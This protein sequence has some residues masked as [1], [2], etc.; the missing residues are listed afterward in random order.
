MTAGRSAGDLAAGWLYTDWIQEPDE[1]QHT[2]LWRGCSA[3]SWSKGVAV[4]KGCLFRSSLEPTSGITTVNESCTVS[5][6]VSV[7]LQARAGRASGRP[8]NGQARQMGTGGRGV[9]KIGQ[10]RPRGLGHGTGREHDSLS[11]ALGCDSRGVRALA[12]MTICVADST[13]R[14]GGSCWGQTE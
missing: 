11:D 6:T 8:E 2:R 13:G 5:N 10:A 14:N 9:P 3:L 7:V 12:Y 4:F 1:V